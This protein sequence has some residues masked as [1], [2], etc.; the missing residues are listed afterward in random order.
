MRRH[1]LILT[2][3]I[4]AVGLATTAA[5][6]TPDPDK[7]LYGLIGSL[8]AKPGQRAAVI[9]AIAGG[10][11]AM[12]G[13]YSYVIAADTTNPDLI[14]ITEVWD[15][16]TSH[17]NSLKLPPVQA[18]IV[19]ARPLIAGFGAQTVTTPVAGGGPRW[20]KKP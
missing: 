15:S 10:S 20:S 19:K 16:K 12:P 14:W 9:A 3:F 8:T 5:A 6:Q 11:D 13:C 7:P 1:T 17:D 2:A 18:A 4:F